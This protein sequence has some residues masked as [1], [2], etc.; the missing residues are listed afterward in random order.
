M[1]RKADLRSRWGNEDPPKKIL[2]K[3]EGTWWRARGKTSV[4]NWGIGD[5][6]FR[7]QPKCRSW[8]IIEPVSVLWFFEPL[9]VGWCLWSLRRL[10]ELVTASTTVESESDELTW[11]FPWSL[12]HEMA[13]WCWLIGLAGRLRRPAVEAKNAQLGEDDICR[14]VWPQRPFSELPDFRMMKWKHA[15]HLPAFFLETKTHFS[16]SLGCCEWSIP[17]F[18]AE[19]TGT[20]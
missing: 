5:C 1:R 19:S 14:S 9:A 17:G 6:T 18:D 20:N 15:P 7:L 8:N 2:E 13:G 3:S 10:H 11:E 16:C 4:S 12:P